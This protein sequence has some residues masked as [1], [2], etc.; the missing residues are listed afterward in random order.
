MRLFPTLFLL[1][2]DDQSQLPHLVIQTHTRENSSKLI[3]YGTPL[4]ILAH[5]EEDIERLIPMDYC[6]YTLHFKTKKRKA[7]LLNNIVPI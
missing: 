1:S 4:F 2:R 7:T 5:F 3:Y 6:S